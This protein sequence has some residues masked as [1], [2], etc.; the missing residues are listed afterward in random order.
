MTYK[1]RISRTVAGLTVA[2]ALLVGLAGPTAA[3]DRKQRQPTKK[4]PTAQTY[5]CKKGG[6]RV[7]A[8]SAAA[9]AVSCRGYGG[10]R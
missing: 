4:P 6:K 2:G 10:L 7:Q 8:R 1:R 3:E 9:A 5:S